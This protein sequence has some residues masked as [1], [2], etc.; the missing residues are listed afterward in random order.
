MLKF[1]NTRKKYIDLEIDE[2]RRIDLSLF[3][4]AED[5][6]VTL[7]LIMLL[8]NINNLLVELGMLGLQMFLIDVRRELLEKQS[9]KFKAKGKKIAEIFNGFIDEMV[10]KE[11]GRA[12]SEDFMADCK[13]SGKVYELVNIL[14]RQYEMNPNI[15]AIIFVKDRS[16]A[17]YLKKILDYVFNKKDRSSSEMC[18]LDDVKA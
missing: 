2:S 16:V 4:N 18:Y 5:R 13:V 12:H 10:A 17:T 6:T 1:I 15:K 7:L 14:E 11:K 8:K 3:K 9:E